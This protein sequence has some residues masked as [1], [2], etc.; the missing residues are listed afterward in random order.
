[1]ANPKI[2]GKC[3]KCGRILTSEY[4]TCETN[5]PDSCVKKIPESG[6]YVLN[7]IYGTLFEET[8]TVNRFGD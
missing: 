2:I 5:R 8:I 7:R 6:K 3:V 4:P 1:M